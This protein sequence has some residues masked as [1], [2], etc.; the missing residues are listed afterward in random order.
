MIKKVVLVLAFWAVGTDAVERRHHHDHRHHS[1]QETLEK[2]EKALPQ[3]SEKQM[4]S[5]SKFENHKIFNE[6]WTASKNRLQDRMREIAERRERMH[7]TQM[8]D[9]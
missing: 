1:V 4:Q 3:Y 2:I 7:R 8:R 5:L 6:V 9:E